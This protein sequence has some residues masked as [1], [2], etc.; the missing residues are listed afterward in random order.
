MNARN[1]AFG[2]PCYKAVHGMDAPPAFC[3][4]AQTLGDGREHPSSARRR[5][6]RDF[7]VSQR[8]PARRERTDDRSVHVA[9]DIT[10]HKRA[11]EEVRQR[12]EELRTT[13]EE[14]ARFNLA[15]V[16]R[17]L[18][19]IELKKEINELCRQT[20]KAVRYQDDH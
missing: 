16:N 7:L 3:P 13:N 4:H 6:E 15:M 5:L 12:M 1:N 10:E 17:D 14:L 18:R 8:R 19:M 2:L 9:R 11:E 20:G